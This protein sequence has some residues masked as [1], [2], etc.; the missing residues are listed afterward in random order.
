VA[1]FGL[2][3]LG[4]NGPIRRPPTVVAA[5]PFRCA[6]GTAVAA[7]WSNSSRCMAQ[8]VGVGE[9]QSTTQPVLGGAHEIHS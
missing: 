2:S 7:T 5:K 1:I 3:G 4:L 6:H 9:R 8:R